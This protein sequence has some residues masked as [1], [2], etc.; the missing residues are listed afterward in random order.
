MIDPRKWT[1]EEDQ[2]LLDLRAAG[3]HIYAI[4]KVLNRTETSVA[5]KIA[6]ARKQSS[7]IGLR[8]KKVL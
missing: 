7:E 1:E 3:K 2:R 4:A 8:A 6:A 5:S